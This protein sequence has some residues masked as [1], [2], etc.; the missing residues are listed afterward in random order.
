MTV[1]V[2]LKKPK[3]E[4]V[5]SVTIG[6]KP[7]DKSA[8]YILATN[9]YMYGGGDGYAMF[10]DAKPLFGVREA[11][12]MANDVMAYIAAKKEIAPKVE[13]RIKIKM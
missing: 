13:G 4:R 7:L 12:L 2:D 8:K 6:G 11:K 9:D 1:E 10:K 5:I 3:N